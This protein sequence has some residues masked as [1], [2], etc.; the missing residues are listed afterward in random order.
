MGRHH[1]AGLQPWPRGGRHCSIEDELC[2]FWQQSP[3]PECSQTAI[4][5]LQVAHGTLPGTSLTVTSTSEAVHI[6]LAYAAAATM[7]EAYL[8]WKVWL[9]CNHPCLRLVSDIYFHK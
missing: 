7:M 4:G 8:E 9:F 2:Y 1:Q 3:S 5:A 6:T